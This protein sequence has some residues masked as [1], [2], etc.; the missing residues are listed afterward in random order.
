MNWK[1]NRQ[2]L[3]NQTSEHRWF[4]YTGQIKEISHAGKHE[5]QRG[6]MLDAL[7]DVASSAESRP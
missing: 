7:A 2:C 3:N 6:G 1:V 4:F 5:L